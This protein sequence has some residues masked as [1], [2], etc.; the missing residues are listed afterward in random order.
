M[1][2][3]DKYNKAGSMELLAAYIKH[4]VCCPDEEAYDVAYSIYESVDEMIRERF[5]DEE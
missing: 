2:T 5:E 3:L 4:E 1:S